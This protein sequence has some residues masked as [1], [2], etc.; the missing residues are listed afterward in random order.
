MFPH[1]LAF[2][3]MGTQTPKA[4]TKA[5]K[6]KSK[7]KELGVSTAMITTTTLR[8]DEIPVV[9]EVLKFRLYFLY[10]YSDK[11]VGCIHISAS[12]YRLER[13]PVQLRGR[14][15]LVENNFISCFLFNLDSMHR[16]DDSIL[17]IAQAEDY[18]CS[19]AS[20]FT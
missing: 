14:Q 18:I 5:L 6:L 3:H 4:A 12:Q 19:S 15:D 7:N 17:L 16:L 13:T 9:L 10:P 20:N 1:E 11:E 8:N 2:I